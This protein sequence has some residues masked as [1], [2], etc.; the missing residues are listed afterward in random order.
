MLR[1]DAQGCIIIGN[2]FARLA[3]LQ[4]KKASTIESVQVTGAERQRIIAILE[5]SLQFAGHGFRPAPIV[6]CF[7]ILG[8]EPNNRIKILNGTTTAEEIVKV[9]QIE[10]LVLG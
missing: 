8:I 1:V 2:G 6:E 5:R 10:G 9:A 7:H 3:H 4:I